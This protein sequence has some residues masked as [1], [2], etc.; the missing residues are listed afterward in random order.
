M[1]RTMLFITFILVAFYSNIFS[2]NSVNK[3]L[4]G[5]IFEDV[6]A[7]SGFKHYGHGK[8]ILFDDYDRDGDLD[9]YL[10][11]VYAPDKFFMNVGNLKFVNLTEEVGLINPHDGHGAVF[12]D[13][14]RNGYKDLF[15]ANNLEYETNRRKRICG[16]N[17]LFMLDD[18]GVFNEKAVEAGVAGNGINQSCGVTTADINN[19]GYLDIFVAVQRFN[20]RGDDCAN[21]LYLNNGNGT[22][23]DIAAEVGVDDRGYGYTCNF[24]DYDND[25]D[26]DLFV[27]NE[28]DAETQPARIL[29]RNDGNLKFTDV[30]EESGIGGS[31]CSTCSVWFDMDNDGDLDLFVG[32]TLT[33]DPARSFAYHATNFNKL[34]KNNGDGTFTDVSKEGGVEI[35][36]K[37]RGCVAGDIDNDGD[38][39]LYVTNS[40]AESLVLINNGEGKFTESK[41]ITGGSVFY[42][43]GCALGDLDNDGDLDLAV[44]NWRRIQYKNP[45]EWKLFKNKTNNENWLKINITGTKSNPEA[46]MSKVYIYAAGHAKD[47]EYLKG[48]HQVTNG[49]GV[50]TGNPLQ[51]HFGLDSSKKYDVVVKF[52]SGIEVVKKNVSTGKTLE[53][54]ESE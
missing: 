27:G 54:V 50:F 18:E 3:Y 15:V 31:G 32:Q 39:D 17:K 9:I 36:T 13:F 25:G 44:G 49:N 22:F 10:S 12:A 19:D 6:T 11:I 45:G 23:K 34:Y 16:P 8:L 1:K 51:Q 42:G 21:H 52:P 14:D 24:V 48:F 28:T 38:L 40:G 46:V 5:T 26:P 20:D 33:G 29:Y 35:D 30:S 47:K 2:Q 7:G 41:K 53:I 37:T 4:N 43:H